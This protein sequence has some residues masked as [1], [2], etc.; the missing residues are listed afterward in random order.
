MWAFIIVRFSLSS[1]VRSSIVQR[2][3][4]RK[5][6]WPY[7][8]QSHCFIVVFRKLIIRQYDQ[9]SKHDRPCGPATPFLQPLSPS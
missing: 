6:G 2:M 7:F 3:R 4:V 8:C 9:L 5:I 1:D